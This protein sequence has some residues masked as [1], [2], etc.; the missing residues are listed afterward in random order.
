[1]AEPLAIPELVEEWLRW[2]TWVSTPENRGRANDDLIG[3]SELEW[4]VREHPE[5][6]WATI[7]A[8]ISDPRAKPY[9]GHLAAGPIEDLLSYHGERFIGRVEVEARSNG[10]FAET[11]NGVWKSTMSDEIWERLLAARERGARGT[12][13]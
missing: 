4:A 7:M 1:M 12:A 9:L 5:H 11:L 3:W 13:K 10:E 6:A 8:V 2:A